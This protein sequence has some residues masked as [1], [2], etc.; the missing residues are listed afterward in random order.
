MEICQARDIHTDRT[1]LSGLSYCFTPKH[2][3]RGSVS[4][5]C[6]LRDLPRAEEFAV[7]E[8]ADWHQLADA[9]GNLYGLLIR[10]TAG[11]RELL[12][13]GTRHEQIARFWAESADN[14]WHG[15]P[16]WRVQER[17]SLNRSGQDY[18]PPRLVFD[19]MVE[20]GILNKTQAGRLNAGKHL[21]KL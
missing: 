11:K 15:H 7:L 17:G 1:R 6:W 2:H 16:L 21:R 14:H 13:L 20:A 9:S 18:R 3:G 19:R 12:E 5:A 8:M 4:D 10:D